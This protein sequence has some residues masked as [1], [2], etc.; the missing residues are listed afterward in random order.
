MNT[1]HEHYKELIK[2][3]LGKKRYTHS[4]NVAEMCKKLSAKYN[5]N[6]DKAY[7]AGLLHDIAKELPRDE[8]YMLVRDSSLAADEIEMQTP[9]LWH[10]IA[11]AAYARDELKI[12]D[13]DIINSIRFHTV[14]RA[15]M[16]LLEKIVYISDKISSE[17]DYNG[18]EELHELAFSNLDLCL[19]TAIKTLKQG[20]EM[21]A[22]TKEAYDYYNKEN[23]NDR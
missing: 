13:T 21:P 6:S 16:S 20:M 9:P 4:I 12:T 5:C 18:V 8:M 17:R 11:G 2:E 22:Y 19:L 14:A 10:A 15:G 23:H 3:K 1:K 7:T